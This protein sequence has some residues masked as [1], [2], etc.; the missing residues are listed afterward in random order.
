[1]SNLS[2]WERRQVE[3]MYQYMEKAEK[4]ADQISNL[5]LKASRWLSLEADEIFERYMTKHNLSEA[6]A[7]S[8]LNELQD[9]TS[10][11]EMLQKLKSKDIKEDKRELIAKLESGAYRARIE[12]LR[13]LQNQLDYVMKNVYDQEKEI[14]T[15][16]Y[17][18]LANEAYY[19]SIFDMHQQ[20]QAAFSFNHI[21]TNQIDKVINSK[22]SGENYSSR[23]WKNTRALAQNLKEE[24]LINLVTGRTEKEVADI[25]ANKFGQSASK[26]RRLVRTESSYL[27]TE[28]NFKAFEEMDVEEYQFLATLDLKT[29]EICRKMDLMIFK[30][31]D[32]TVGLNAP[33]MH[34]WCRSMIVAI[35]D[36]KFLE[37]KKRAAID[38]ETGKVI[39]VPRTM[40]YDEWYS[41]Y[42]KGNKVSELEEKK[43]KNRSSD[44]NQYER[45]KDVIGD[46]VPKTL[47]EFQE[48]KYNDTERW[49]ELKHQYRVVNQYDIVSGDFSTKD[50]CRLDN[51]FT[52]ERLSFN[53]KFRSQG[54]IAIAEFDGKDYVAHSKVKNELSPGYKNYKGNAEFVFES[55]NRCFKT[56]VL[57]ENFGWD[58][59]VDSEAKIFEYINTL[60]NGSKQTL[61]LMTHLPMCD[62]CVGVLQQ[63][64]EKY[65]NMQINIIQKKVKL[66]EKN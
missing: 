49:T 35:I 33:P 41:K 9:R 63:F 7:R 64:R 56:K 66:S 44:R 65:P 61:N 2:Y 24:L 62:S 15:S 1:M 16:H 19:R 17:V 54:N 45:Y 3:N 29:S 55:Q 51:K 57:P 27:S 36:R 25:I 31:K 26:A 59:K 5:Y 20:T 11:D 4:A 10:I 42:V 52:T 48:I 6:E 43:I 28:M 37:N 53:S 12:R 22:W 21:D 40:T 13:Q 60:A 46:E 14:S 32:R 8:L 30:V 58:R 38:P 50:I 34:P 47:E 39:Y 18:D 23:I